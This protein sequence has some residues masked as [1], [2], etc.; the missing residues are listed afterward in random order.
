MIK[1]DRIVDAF[2]SSPTMLC[3]SIFGMILGII[4][5]DMWIFLINFGCGYYHF[6]KIWDRIVKKLNT[7]T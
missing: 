1:L 6:S 5:S 4:T 2:L 3:V 7:K